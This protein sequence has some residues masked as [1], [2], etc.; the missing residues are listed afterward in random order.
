MTIISLSRRKAEQPTE[1]DNPAFAGEVIVDP[2]D[3][4]VEA[5]N[6]REIYSAIKKNLSDYEYTIWHSYML[7]K[8]A[9]EIGEMLGKDE[10][11]VS[12]AVYRIR[13]KL[14]ALLK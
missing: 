4:I 9:K 11:S 13:K 3:D 2:A 7:G 8:T 12:N 6:I 14:R 10:K 5:E 1:L